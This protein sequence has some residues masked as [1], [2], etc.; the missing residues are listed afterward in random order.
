MT[1]LRAGVGLRAGTPDQ[2]TVSVELVDGRSV[3]TFTVGPKHRLEPL[4]STT[5]DSL[6]VA[7]ELAL[8]KRLPLVAWISS[9]GPNANEGISAAH[10]WGRAAAALV[11]CSGTVPTILVLD[12]PAVAGTALLLGIADHVIMVDD[13]YAFVSGP[14]MVEEFTGVPIAHDDL[15]GVATHAARSGVATAVAAD[16][17][18]A[19]DLVVDLLS[20]LPAHNDELAPRN[21]AAEPGGAV[22]PELGAIVPDSPTGSYDVREVIAGICDEDTTLEV[23][24]DWAPSIVTAFARI[25]GRSI[26]IVANQP[27]ALAGTLNIEAS[28][29]GAR[30]VALCDAFSLPI[31]TLVD[32]PGFQPGKDLEWR[33]MIRHGAELAFA[34]ARAT[35]PRVSLTLRKSY[36]GA[37]IVMDSKYM[38]NDMAYAWPTAEIAVMGAK[39]AVE[40]LHR[41]ADE[42]E[43]AERQ[44]EYEERLLNP[45]RA[46]ER[47]S[48]DAIIEPNQSRHHI[49]AALDL[50]ETKA[51]SHVA[52]IHDNSPL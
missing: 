9:S 7:C 40:I 43:R 46:A 2:A 5:S 48:V 36:G 51:E 16:H 49:A 26:G 13:S 34:Y 35:V 28:Q 27:Q 11:E 47:G 44:R 37:Y 19:R 42:S 4:S 8:Q 20:Y 50:L 14:R 18:E 31:L 38:G 10:S 24:S 15:G 45:Y 52:R 21:L 12:G 17:D 22:R 6:T 41:R 25:D 32:T 29:K 33:G 3:V 1:G 39:G 30:F 23:R